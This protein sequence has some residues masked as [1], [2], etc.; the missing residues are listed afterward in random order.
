MNTEIK[1][2]QL[3]AGLITESEYRENLDTDAYG[4]EQTEVYIELMN[5]IHQ[6]GGERIDSLFQPE[7]MKEIR[8]IIDTLKADREGWQYLR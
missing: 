7:K 6:I 8:N 5:V 1:K 3:L 4:L 2:M